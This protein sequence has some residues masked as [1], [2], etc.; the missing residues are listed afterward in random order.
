MQSDSSYSAN[1]GEVWD[2][3]GKDKGGEGEEK[4]EGGEKG[5]EGGGRNLKGGNDGS[6][7]S[8]W[9]N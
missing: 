7:A 2:H 4:E 6:E 9:P 3:E 5:K 1:V 8:A